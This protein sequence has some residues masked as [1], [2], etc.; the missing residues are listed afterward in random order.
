[1]HDSHTRKRERGAGGSCAHLFSLVR[2][3]A[4]PSLGSGFMP[5]YSAHTSFDPITPSF[6]LDMQGQQQ[7]AQQHSVIPP[8]TATGGAVKNDLAFLQQQQPQQHTQQQ[9]APVIMHLPSS[10]NAALSYPTPMQSTSLLGVDDHPYG[11]MQAPLLSSSGSA[12]PLSSVSPALQQYASVSPHHGHSMSAMGGDSSFGSASNSALSQSYGVGH[13]GSLGYGSAQQQQMQQQGPFA[14]LNYPSVKMENQPFISQQQLLQQQQQR[15]FNNP[16]SSHQPQYQNPH[17]PQMRQAQQQP[18]P[19]SIEQQ[20]PSSQSQLTHPP[21]L[22]S[23]QRGSDQL[24]VSSVSSAASGSTPDAHLV[25]LSGASHS[26][27]SSNHT[28]PL[29]SS[30]QS[31]ANPN[32][33]AP[34][35]HATSPTP[36]PSAM[37]PIVHRNSG[38]RSVNENASAASGTTH[39]LVGTLQ[40]P[41]DILF[42]VHLFAGSGKKKSWPSR[43][44][45]LQSL[46]NPSVSFAQLL[47][48]AA[49]ISSFLSVSVDGKEVADATEPGVTVCQTA[50]V[51]ARLE[52][53]AQAASAQGL[54]TTHARTGSTSH[55]R[56]NDDREHSLSSSSRQSHGSVPTH[57]SSALD[58]PPLE[59]VYHFSDNI[60]SCTRLG[61]LNLLVIKSNRR[62][63]NIC[64][65]QGAEIPASLLRRLIIH[66]HHSPS[67]Y[68]Y[69]DQILEEYEYWKFDSLDDHSIANATGGSNGSAALAVGSSSANNGA[70]FPFAK[71]AGYYIAF[72]DAGTARHVQRDFN[73]KIG[74]S[75]GGGGGNGHGD[76][77][78][79]T[80]VEVDR[81]FSYAI[82]MKS[83]F[84]M[85]EVKARAD[86]T[87]S[88][89]NSKNGKD[90]KPKSKFYKKV[91]KPNQSRAATSASAA[92]AAMLHQQQQQQQAGFLVPF[93]GGQSVH[94]TPNASSRRFD[95]GDDGGNGNVN[96]A[97]NVL[98]I[99]HININ[100]PG[101]SMP[102]L[103]SPPGTAASQQGSASRTGGATIEI[104]D[105]PTS[106]SVH[107]SDTSFRLMKNQPVNALLSVHES[108]SGSSSSSS[109]SSSAAAAATSSGSGSSAAEP[110]DSKPLVGVP[111]PVVL[112]YRDMDSYQRDV[113]SGGGGGG[114]FNG[115]GGG[116]GG[117]S[118]SGGNDSNDFNS[119]GNGNGNGNGHGNSGSLSGHKRSRFNGP[120]SGN[121]GNSHPMNTANALN[122]SVLGGN[123]QMGAALG[124]N[125]ASMAGVAAAVNQFAQV[126]Q[127]QQLQQQLFQ[128]VAMDYGR[129]QAPWVFSDMSAAAVAQREAA[130]IQQPAGGG[131]TQGDIELMPMARRRRRGPRVGPDGDTFEAADDE[132]DDGGSN[133]NDHD[134]G[135]EEEIPSESQ[136]Q[137][138]SEGSDEASASNAAAPRHKHDGAVG[139]DGDS[140]LGEESGELMGELSQSESAQQSLAE[141]GQRHKLSPLAPPSGRYSQQPWSGAS[142]AS[143]MG[144]KKRANNGGA[145]GVD[146]DSSIAQ[147]LLV[148]ELD[149][150]VH[151]GMKP[152]IKSLQ[153]AEEPSNLPYKAFDGMGPFAGFWRSFH[154]WRQSFYG[155]VLSL[156]FGVL[157]LVILSKNVHRESEDSFGKNLQLIFYS[158]DIPKPLRYQDPQEVGGG[159]RR[160]LYEGHQE[161]GFYYESEDQQAV[162]EAYG[163]PD[164]HGALQEVQRA[165]R[166]SKTTNAAVSSGNGTDTSDPV[167]LSRRLAASLQLFASMRESS[168]IYNTWA[169]SAPVAV[170]NMLNPPPGA[171]AVVNF[172]VLSN[173]CKEGVRI[174]RAIGDYILS[175]NGLLAAFSSLVAPAMFPPVTTSTQLCG[176]LSGEVGSIFLY[177]LVCTQ[178]LVGNS[179][180]I[181]LGSTGLSCSSDKATWNAQ[182]NPD[183][184]VEVMENVHSIN[185]TNAFFIRTM[186]THTD[187][188]TQTQIVRSAR[189]FAAPPELIARSPRGDCIL[190]TFLAAPVCPSLFFAPAYNTSASTGL[191][192]TVYSASGPTTDVTPTT[193]AP[194]SSAPSTVAPPPNAAQ[195]AALNALP[196]L[197]ALAF[198]SQAATLRSLCTNFNVILGLISQLALSSSP[199][200][201]P[202]SPTSSSTLS[203]YSAAAQNFTTAGGYKASGTMMGFV[204][205]GGFGLLMIVQLILFLGL[206]LARSCGGKVK[207]GVQGMA[208]VA[209]PEQQAPKQQ[210]Q[211][212][213]SGA[214]A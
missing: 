162:Q 197:G 123:L 148:E 124:L 107:V 73:H 38:V 40:S 89:G 192:P 168:A 150:R 57:Y 131:G 186:H 127:A 155:T 33:P 87:A 106:N 76:S 177:E 60:K 98:H 135:D 2:P 101:L 144:V 175:R 71:Q 53:V 81:N 95:N 145:A 185:M 183:R 63:C 111:T 37:A 167:T 147:M 191:N 157:A 64:Q 28:S 163:S 72:V 82:K 11:G 109:N 31:P 151:K 182:L 24:S 67:Q 6:L 91:G 74:S 119:G 165:A 126:A 14:D 110:V 188:Q 137:S 96:N 59:I 122:L 187:T 86:G 213:R 169:S 181:P 170:A 21:Q 196:H 20:P 35:Q 78:S 5:D 29:V 34:L 130:G 195:L 194:G 139:D 54:S 47:F 146:R 190:L 104:I 133:L 180:T 142:P 46:N 49:N 129:F 208:E 152:A 36:L 200:T 62:A 90:S 209:M 88:G 99:N 50:A 80:M 202:S 79:S 178:W 138:G 44:I 32:S 140:A 75:S 164:I 30:P 117:N 204:A 68:A 128:Q 16:P 8:P 9:Q 120:S 19:M 189:A 211:P 102:K 103:L 22:M 65:S 45:S 118:G 66:P 113:S 136:Q 158:T 42:S 160:A 108:A 203:D 176:V 141:G 1:M 41:T 12:A 10:S 116:F 43:L 84:W 48:H 174:A 212:A 27:R 97:Q 92:A 52:Q 143:H 210:V 94:T 17:Q 55:L 77:A 7:Q 15:S 4:L 61:C 13:I 26:D 18:Q 184:C 25:A 70:G 134:D 166:L 85:L 153:R 121:G 179:V 100:M 171:P 205:V 112:V 156:L 201:T 83:H 214:R 154:F 149:G 58:L 199:T 132:K 207:A 193:L 93:A 105:E 172:D 51:K 23:R 115:N 69:L 114:G 56:P 125:P 159:S 173:N 206:L 39:G 161:Q 3:A 198:Y